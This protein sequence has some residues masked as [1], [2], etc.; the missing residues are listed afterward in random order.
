MLLAFHK[1]IVTLQAT[2]AQLQQNQQSSQTLPSQTPLQLLQICQ[3]NDTAA[4]Y[5]IMFR[6]QNGWNGASL[7]AFYCEGLRS[8]LQ[9]N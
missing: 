5:V 8:V 6:T 7:Q 1:Q 3:S 2:N 9:A 4:N